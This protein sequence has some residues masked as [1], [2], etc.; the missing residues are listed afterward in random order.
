MPIGRRKPLT[1][2]QQFVNLRGNPVCRGDG[3]LRAGRFTWR[4]AT[5][6]SPFG[7]DYD[8]RIE[9][10]QGSTPEV[11]VDC[12]DLHA[13]AGARRIPHLYQQRI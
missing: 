1:T 11:F 5:T 3:E 8:I 9:F 4:Y 2:T 13:L 6:P 10:K 12:P 7:R